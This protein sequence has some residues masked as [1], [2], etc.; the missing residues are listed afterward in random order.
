M[1]NNTMGKKFKDVVKMTLFGRNDKFITDTNSIYSGY[2]R[3]LQTLVGGGING[4]SISNYGAIMFT[5]APSI[6]FTDT[7]NKFNIPLTSTITNNYINSVRSVTIN[8]T[9]TNFTLA[10]TLIFFN[11]NPTTTATATAN[12]TGGSVSSVT[13]TNYGNGYS[14]IPS[15]AWN[16]G[17]IMNITAT[18]AANVLTGFTIT[19][20]P[21]YTTA[22]TILITGGGG[23]T[24]TTTCTLTGNTISAIALPASTNY[25]SAPTVYIV[26]GTGTGTSL[27]TLTPNMGQVLNTVSLPTTPYGQFL[28][29]PTTSFNGGGVID[30]TATLTGAAITSFTIN[31]GGYTNCFS[32]APTIILSDGTN[33]TTTTCTLT[34]GVITAVA[35]PASNNNFTLTPVVS[36]SHASLAT[37]S[38]NL[39]PYKYNIGGYSTNKNIK[40]L[41]FE[42]SNELQ[43]LR[44]AENAHLY[45]ELVR[46]PAFGVNG[47][48]YRALRLVGSQNINT[49][50]GTNGTTG[51]PILF[52]TEYFNG[53]NTFFINEKSFARLPVPQKFLSKGYLEFELETI[54]TAAGGAFTQAQLNEIIIKL[55]IE[56]PHNEYTQDSNLEMTN[57]K[58][59]I[60]INHFNY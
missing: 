33:Y 2:D 8:T 10:P 35:N 38:F 50:D 18:V 14:A 28:T 15:I 17:G 7:S 26:C 24:Q 59:H 21:T 19:T 56:E 45:L 6:H 49:F 31:N 37:F 58:N 12:L 55:N 4:V 22:P 43:Q 11:G 39:N 46:M 36:V 42:L 25:T 54:M 9:P 48:C 52:I 32:S 44:L 5:S 60:K 34:N 41:R 23:L 1:N 29:T 40:L 20:S 3:S 57:N 47:S 53:A 16:G 27:F 51:N 13:M 30:I